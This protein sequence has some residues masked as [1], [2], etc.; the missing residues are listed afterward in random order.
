MDAC[1]TVV[2]PLIP[3]LA[4]AALMLASPVAMRLG[5]E[6][7][8]ARPVFE[9]MVPSA[10]MGALTREP[11]AIRWFESSPCASVTPNL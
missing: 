6:C 1:S 7:A 8:H 4:A 3:P 5:N 9:L 11:Q 10:S 2:T